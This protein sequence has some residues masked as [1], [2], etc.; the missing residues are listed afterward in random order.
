LAQCVESIVDEL[1]GTIGFP[2][3]FTFPFGRTTARSIEELFGAPGDGADSSR[4]FEDTVSASLATLLP[5]AVCHGF[6]QEGGI[7][8]WKDWSLWEMTN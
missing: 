5:N 7:D 4:P 1:P 8:A 2:F 3:N 6:T